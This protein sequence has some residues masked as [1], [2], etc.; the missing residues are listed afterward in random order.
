MIKNIYLRARNRLR[1]IVKD[2][3]NKVNQV[4]DIYR[5]NSIDIG[6]CQTTRSRAIAEG[7]VSHVNDIADRQQT[8]MINVADLPAASTN[9]TAG[10]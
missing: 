2:M 7:P 8:V 6:L 5:V 10:N 1:T 9:N 4:L 3:P